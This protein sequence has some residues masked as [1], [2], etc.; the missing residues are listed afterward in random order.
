MVALTMWLLTSMLWPLEMART[1]SGTA[2]PLLDPLPVVGLVGA[3]I[4][5]VT[6]VVAEEPPFGSWYHNF[7]TYLALINCRTLSTSWASGSGY[8]RQ[9]HVANQIF[10]ATYIA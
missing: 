7:L 3:E 9:D 5:D 6:A 8:S 2:R 4:A 10:L 1:R